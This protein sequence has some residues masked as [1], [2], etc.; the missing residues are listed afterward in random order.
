[1]RQSG[2]INYLGIYEIF[3]DPTIYKEQSI[4]NVFQV[5]ML[6]KSSKSFFTI[7]IFFILI[8]FL[9][10][11]LQNNMFWNMNT[12]LLHNLLCKIR[13]IQHGEK[14]LAP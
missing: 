9:F 1:M 14:N 11:I 6:L 5:I 7:K 12:S 3:Q 10:V 2:I 13:K 8:Q 4:F